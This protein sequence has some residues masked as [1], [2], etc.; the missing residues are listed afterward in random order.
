[1]FSGGELMWL[2]KLTGDRELVLAQRDNFKS[3]LKSVRFTA[4]GGGAHGN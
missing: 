2:F 1:L 3:F 4:A